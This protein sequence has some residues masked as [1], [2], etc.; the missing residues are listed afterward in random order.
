VP[1]TSAESDAPTRHAWLRD[2]QKRFVGKKF[3]SWPVQTI[4]DAGVQAFGFQ[5]MVFGC[6]IGPVILKPGE[7]RA[8][9]LVH[10][11]EPH[12]QPIHSAAGVDRAFV[13]TALS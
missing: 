2:S 8:K 9:I 10:E 12:D 4:P 6:Q 13:P 11:M 5:L 7:S 3:P 1:G